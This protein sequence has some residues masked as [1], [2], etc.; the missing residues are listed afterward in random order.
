MLYF[1]LHNMSW[2]SF[3][4]NKHKSSPWN[5]SSSSELDFMDAHNL[6]KQ[7]LIDGYWGCIFLLLFLLIQS[8]LNNTAS[9]T[10]III[11]K[12][13]IPR[14]VIMWIKSEHI[15]HTE[16]CEITCHSGWL[17]TTCFHQQRSHRW[18]LLPMTHWAG[19]LTC[20]FQPEG[21][22]P[23]HSESQGWGRGWKD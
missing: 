13:Y 10:H 19:R 17:V 6:L 14:R 12:V 22:R 16:T 9:H 1:S 5:P 15:L 2:A 7:F 4:V 3:Q 21:P 11:P 23:E 18:L 8:S 20:G